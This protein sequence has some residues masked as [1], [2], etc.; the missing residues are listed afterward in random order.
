MKADTILHE[1]ELCARSALKECLN[2]GK[3]EQLLVV[4]DKPCREIGRA[5]WEA[6]LQLARDAVLVEITP[7]KQNGN[8]P[9]DPVGE[10]FGRFNVV[11]LPTSK[12]LSHTQ[13]RRLACDKG[14]RIATLPGITPDVFLRTMKA[15][16]EKLGLYTR[17]VAGNLCAAST[18]HVTTDSGTDITFQTG[19][20]QA[21][22]DDGRLIYKG[23]FGNLPAG[24]AYLAPLEGTA[25]GTIVIDGSFSL[26]GLLTSPLVLTVKK[27]K[28]INVDSATE[29]GTELERLFV[30]YGTAAKNLAEFGVGT[31]DC[32]KITGNTL[33]DEKV[34]GTIHFAVGDNASMG[35]TVHVPLHLDGIVK[36]PNVW[37]DA[38]LWMDHGVLVQ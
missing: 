32:A 27:G 31:L 37:L 20:R 28:V 29:A 12:S 4:C 36:K 21:K 10:M 38:Q 33:E 9:P 5:F 8:E 11:V 17:R 1:L 13:A 3:Q 7:R 34:K 30:K 26:G 23:A 22:A 14:A 6:G 18:I 24:E 2:L 16:W 15:D 25:N 19:G 35:G